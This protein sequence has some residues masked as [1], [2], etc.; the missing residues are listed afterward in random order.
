MPTSFFPG[1]TCIQAPLHRPSMRER[2]A[3]PSTHADVLFNAGWS[4]AQRLG[5]RLHDWRSVF[6]S[7]RPDVIVHNYAP[8]A[9]LAAQT[10]R[11]R[12]VLFGT[13]FYD[14]PDMTPLPD[15]CPWRDNYP[16]QLL[17][18]ERRVLQ[19]I[20]SQLNACG[21]SPLERVA[22]LSTRADAHLLITYP[23]MDHYRDRTTGEYVGPWGELPGESPCWPNVPGMR[24][25]AYLK[26]MEA[27]PYL[28]HYLRHSR[29]PTLVYAP[30]AS[31][32][33]TSFDSDSLSVCDR[34][35]DIKQISQQCDLAILNAGH[36]TTL[37]MLLAGKP[38]LAIPLSG[39][40]HLV[41]QNIVRLNAGVCVSPHEYHQAV[42]SLQLML[43]ENR[44]AIGAQSF[45]EKY[46]DIR[47]ERHVQRV[48]E[49]L[50]TVAR[51]GG[52]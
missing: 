37:Q 47:R 17:M 36:N 26:S 6:D 52:V 18:T 43:G 50:E 42:A 44:F 25:F 22:Q 1:L 12:S 7:I 11:A 31:S 48:L 46:A 29:L 51:N 3:E 41:A 40:Q 9:F 32:V 15:I 16:D 28:L 10:I 19:V 5:E 20:N 35:L 34:P 33:A 30:N 2:I 4:N 21:I 27:L 49:V 23:E 45:A 24:V 8:T 13:G 39:E 38:I 14:P